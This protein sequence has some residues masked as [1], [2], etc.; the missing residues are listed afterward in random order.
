MGRLGCA[1]AHVQGRTGERFDAQGREADTRSDNVDDRVDGA[2]FVEVNLLERHVMDSGFGYTKI[3][4][5]GGGT[6]LHGRREW[7]LTDDV[8]NG[9]ERAVRVS[10]FGL[11]LDVSRGH[12]I[13]P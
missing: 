11:D 12:P 2:D 10:V 4:E 7:G 5:D 1:S 6:L 3:A 13:L 8:E 9:A